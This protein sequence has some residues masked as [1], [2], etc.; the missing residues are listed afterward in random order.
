MSKI[1]SIDILTIEQ[2]GGVVCKNP[3]IRW[4]KPDC[5]NIICELV[6]D[7]N[8]N[9]K[10]LKVQVPEDCQNGCIDVFIDC[11]ENCS[12]C[13][14]QKITICPCVTNSECPDCQ[15]CGPK[16]YCITVCKE[17]EFCSGDRCVECDE[18]N[19]CK[20]GEICDD[21]KCKCPPSKPYKN[22]K[23]ECVECNQNTPLGPCESCVDGKIVIKKCPEGVCHPVTGD[24]VECIKNSDCKKPNEKCGPNGCECEKGFVR[25]IVT[26]DCEPEPDCERDSD[27]G[28]CRKCL[29]SGK[30]GDYTCPP[31]YVP[32]K[33]PGEC[34]V[35]LC[36]CS[37]PS[38]PPGYVCHKIDNGTCVC[39]NCNVRCKDGK[40]PEGC[41]CKDG[42]NCGPKTDPCKY[43][44]CDEC[45]KTPGCD[46]TTPDNCE[47]SPCSG[48][49][50]ENHPCAP[51]CG[52]DSTHNCINCNKVSCSQDIE[53]PENCDCDKT[54]GKCKGK[55]K[56]PDGDDDGD[57]DGGDT[58]CTDTIKVIDNGDCSIK[59]VLNTS[60]CCD[61]R[62]IYLHANQTANSNDRTVLS[63]LRIGENATDTLLSATGIVNDDAIQ[64]TI[65]YT[66]EQ[67]AREVNST[68][69]VIAG[70]DVITI[71]STA[72]TLFSNSDQSTVSANIKAN[73]SIISQGGKNYKITETSMYA[74][75]VGVIRNTVNECTYRLGKVL[76]YRKSGAET[77]NYPAMLDRVQKCKTPI[78]YWYKS[79]DGVSWTLI[80]KVY[81]TKTGIGKYEDIL[82]KEHG[83]ELCKYFKLE[84]DC[85]C[86]KEAY[87]SCSGT[88]KT[89]YVVYQPKTLDI[90]HLD[91][92]GKSIKIK[93][94]K[95]CDLI[96][97]DS[98]PY[99]LYINGS[100][101]GEYHV[102]SGSILFAGDLVITKDFTIT[103]V[104]LE[105][106]CDDC[107]KPL[108]IT[109][110]KLS[111]DCET[112]TDSLMTLNASGN[113][114]NGINISGKIT[115][116]SNPLIAISNC[117]I[118]VQ[119]NGD[120]TIV[121][122]DSN[123]DFF[124][125]HPITQ[126]GS[127]TI[128]AI[129][130]KGCEK[131]VTVQ[132]TDCCAAGLGQVLYNCIT[133]T[134]S[135]VLNGCASPNGYTLTKGGIIISQGVYNPNIVLSTALENGLYELT[136]DCGVGCEPTKTF[137]VSCG[138]PDFNANTNCNGLQGRIVVSGYT[139]GSGAPY[140][141][142][143]ST[144][145][146][147]SILG[148]GNTD[149]YIINTTAGAT[150]QIRIK[151][152]AGNY[153]NVKTVQGLDCSVNT[154]DYS[155]ITKCMS[156]VKKYCFTP[157]VSGTFN[158]VVK[159]VNGAVV[160]NQNINATSGIETCVN[161]STNP[162]IG[163]GTV[164]ITY[165]GNTISKTV[166]II[167]CAT[168]TINYDCNTGLQVTGVTNFMV[169]STGYPS[170]GYGPYLATEPNLFF[171][172]GINASRILIIKSVD[173][174]QTYGQ[175]TINC[176]THS[177]V[178]E[179]D[180][181]VGD[182]PRLKVKLTGVS[183]NYKV[184]I[185][186]GSSFICTQNITHAGGT[187]TYPINCALVS[188]TNY[189]VDVENLNYGLRSY[190]DSLVG[191]TE[192]KV[193]ESYTST[194]CGLTGGG[195]GGTGGGCPI[196]T[197]DFIITGGCN[198]TVTNNSSVSVQ[199]SFTER[200]GANCTGGILG[201][202]PMQTIASG[203]SATFTL[204]FPAAYHAWSAVYQNPVGDPCAVAGCYLGCH[205]NGTCIGINDP[206]VE[207]INT[208]SYRRLKI[209]NT[210][211]TD[212]VVVSIN[213]TDHINPI[214]AGGSVFIN[215]PLSD[216]GV[217]IVEFR[218]VNDQTVTTGPVS[219]TMNC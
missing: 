144:D 107:N 183:G 47:K 96:T 163:T 78:F 175:V 46:C 130:C 118:K 135:S 100:L 199:F 111:V 64:G 161:F 185:Y 156:G 92:C 18:N 82:K 177:V 49:C 197:S 178:L 209:T 59:G 151:D 72:T 77:G 139:G 98:P 13:G 205:T 115:L 195:G 191:N 43:L 14:E 128:K 8:G 106:P 1:Y 10:K 89:R 22:L 60:E 200:T 138:L 120:E 174:S 58:N 56:D 97:V 74:E 154:F 176:C 214:L 180:N 169:H 85:G 65:K 84:S 112:C 148:A 104:K 210:S 48:P 204:Q 207:C 3:T 62:K 33:I 171:T 141:V 55:T 184:D 145:N 103:E 40:C 44:N 57:G 188:N 155:T 68:N 134:V 54:I 119:V 90:K 71:S 212:A 127:Y 167:D 172:D 73:G 117:E 149:P 182:S 11:R 137:T 219:I 39:I 38:C 23:G 42:D 129:N 147:S 179:D 125:N 94:V 87:Y 192:C 41:I 208:G 136:I 67:V 121:F 114:I 9:V 105:Y 217:K 17:N 30:C 31:G 51:G 196:Q 53:C 124:L 101:E 122:S 88:D 123:G 215:Y 16:G 168:V 76:L 170:G 189:T 26:G 203:G 132:I 108:I 37:N 19:P 194:N 133:K 27:C 213:G 70:G 28:D 198:P 162:S 4:E 61:C 36:D 93:E 160:L 95:V 80:K 91:P 140:T 164:D 186:Q 159:D 99:K 35:K 173:G 166:N 15:V 24:C 21:G 102:N 201:G 29:Q 165:N 116:K 50:D 109:L 34:C 143:Y 63:Q 83:L 25:N 211:A 131:T 32:S 218:C 6:K 5:A 152:S 45:K 150:Y 20:N 142:E 158:V 216:T 81:S 206:V 146:F 52:C 69:T 7:K 110:P 157:T 2:S 79:M 193:T 12:T 126:N 113:C 66:W 153:S 187:V 86:V 190:K 181:C 202:P 75:S